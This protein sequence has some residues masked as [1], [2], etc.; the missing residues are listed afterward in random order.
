MNGTRAHPGPA[1]TAGPAAD[2]A[3]QTQPWNP[4]IH[5]NLTA[6]VLRASTQKEDNNSNTDVGH[7]LV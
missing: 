3:K 5:P 2:P 4:L 6:T 7:I 1:A